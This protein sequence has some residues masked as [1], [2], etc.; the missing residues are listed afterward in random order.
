[1]NDKFYP[2]AQPS[3]TDKEHANVESALKSGWISSLGP[4][5]GEFERRFAEFCGATYGIA[6]SNGTVGLHLALR[7]LGVEEGDEVIV[8]DLS[9][10]AT[11]NTVLMAGAT[12]IFCDIDRETLCIDAA[13]IA[14]KIT[15]R[16]KAVVPVHLY[17]HP[18]D[19]DAINALARGHGLK[20]IEDAAEAHGAEMRGRRVGGL[21]DCGV[22]SFYANKNLTTGEGGMITTNDARLAERVRL[23]RDHAM[24][25]TRRYWH[26]E[27]GYNYRLTNIQAAIGCAQLDRVEFLLERKREIFAWYRENLASIPNVAVNRTAPWAKNAYWLVCLELRDGDEMRRDRFMQALRGKGIDSRP[28]FYPMS[29]MPYFQDAN[30]PVTHEVAKIGINLPT[31]VDLR[32]EDVD[33]ICSEIGVALAQM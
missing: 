5:V 20:V 10:I 15:A 13:Q 3:I 7:A 9:F 17:G 8:P 4:H 30:T 19:M 16:T 31:Y 29:D 1:M 22:F 32:R 26:E 21:G 23:L 2:V 24:S 33:Y 27:L 28:Y 11:A 14:A 18:A 6:V 12:P 25:K